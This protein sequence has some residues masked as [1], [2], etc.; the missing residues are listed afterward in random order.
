MSPGGA[1]AARLERSA[2][3]Q[4]VVVTSGQQPGLFGG[5][6]YTWSKALSALAFADAVQE[7]TGIPV[8][9]VFWAA[10][11]DADFAEASVTRVAVPGGVETL[12]LPSPPEIGKSL[13]DVPLPDVSHLIDALARGA[14]AATNADILITVREAYAAGQTVGGAYVSLLRRL[15]EPLGIA[16]LD[17]GHRAVRRA[18]HP[19]LRQAL[20]RATEID[21]A[22][23][24]RHREITDAGYEPQVPM[25]SGL[26]LGFDTSSGERRRVAISDAS[27]T[28]QNTL[29][30]ML[31]PNVLLRPVAEWSILPTIAYMAGPGELAYFAQVSAVASAM[32]RDA[33][34]G[35]PRWSGTIVEPH[36]RRILDR[37]E[38]ELDELRDPHAAE[39]RLAR[40]RVSAEV[41][42]GLGRAR[43][44]LAELS[45]DLGA[46]LRTPPMLVSERVI[47]G[48]QRDLEHRIDRLERRFTAAVKQRE[49]DM[50]RDIGTARGALFPDGLP[51]E[52]ALNL[53]PL[54]AR[55]GPRLL[56]LLS[57]RAHEHAAA[58]VGADVQAVA[59]SRPRE[60]A[61]EHTPPSPSPMARD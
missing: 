7:A 45:R 6:I 52:R 60:T 58:L 25:V 4:G 41:R 9:P 61:A 21:E 43:A 51:Q 26:S 18:L 56:D 37:Y 5:P 29:A 23:R 27:T 59:A 3:G 10:T 39:T 47:A 36:V 13:R 38:L 53:I 12:R 22:L 49:R 11:D 57:E 31:G 55:H 40:D 46:A 42:E 20:M 28:A 24:A 34:L 33:P 16:V 48:S 54:I 19:V 30:D 17:A 2:R 32:D 44:R 35:V 1:A 14:G 8:A 50:L 15:L